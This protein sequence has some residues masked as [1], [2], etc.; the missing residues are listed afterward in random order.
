MDT[1]RSA[2][3]S[4]AYKWMFRK[5]RKIKRISPLK[6]ELANL[7]KA[8]TRTEKQLSSLNA[9]FWA[10][11]GVCC[12]ACGVQGYSELMSKQE[13]REKRIAS[14]KAKLGL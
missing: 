14:I 10:N 8:H 1:I 4:L 12:P 5:A 7:Q 6:I 3:Y 11:N 13:R 9:N 2:L